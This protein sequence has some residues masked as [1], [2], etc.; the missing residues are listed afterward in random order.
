MRIRWLQRERK[1]L[2]EAIKERTQELQE[3]N[4]E[5]ESFAYTV[6]HD[7]KDPVGVIVGYA[8]VL[9]DFLKKQ[10]VHGA[11]QFIEGIK[12]NSDRIIRFIDD[13]LQLSRSGKVIEKLAPTDSKIIVSQIA[14][15]IGQKKKLKK[16]YL[17]IKDLPVV[18]ADA[19][20]LYMIFYNLINNAYKY[21]NK[22]RPLKIS[23]S[24]L[25]NGDMHQFAVKDNGIGI[26]EA[27]Y[28]RIFQPGVRLKV[29]DTNG[30]G[31]GL[32]IVKKIVEAHGGKI[33]IESELGSGSTFYFTLKAVPF[34]EG[35]K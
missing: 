23:I 21:R 17:E 8:H 14:N 7:L 11:N 35:G 33:W 9:E 31:F 18:M 3:K 34:E 26:K 27:D 4:R 6:S 16:N 12:R 19:D 13:M 5:L 10:N 24:Y 1:Q 28:K 25:R 30:A 32:R 29:I 2:R 15:E 20:R 22:K